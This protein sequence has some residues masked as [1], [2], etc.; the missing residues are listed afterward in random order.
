MSLKNLFIL[1]T[2]KALAAKSFEFPYFKTDNVTYSGGYPNIVLRP[3]GPQANSQ[4][5]EPLDVVSSQ[6]DSSQ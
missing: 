4:W 1:A 5:R 3:K 6:R 2:C